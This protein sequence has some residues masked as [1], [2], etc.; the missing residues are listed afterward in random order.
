MATDDEIDDQAATWI[1]RLDRGLTPAERWR[2]EGWLAEDGR[3]HQAMERLAGAWTAADRAKESPELMRLAREM[4]VAVR[5]PRP[6]AY[7]WTA[8]AATA[9]VIAAG[10][11]VGV[12]HRSA[13]AVTASYRVVPPEAR[14]LT[15][16]DGSVVQL[17]SGGSFRA[18]YSPMVRRVVLDKG[19][20]HFAVAKNP[21]RPFVVSLG[22]V[23]V[24]A[25][26]TAIE[27]RREPQ[28]IEILVTEGK[29]AVEDG[30]DPARPPVV[31]LL[32]AGNRAT[33]RLD[34]AGRTAGVMLDAP[35]PAEVDRALAWS[36]T[37]LV[38]DRTPLADA[39]D[40]FNRRNPDRLAIADPAIRG[41]RLGGTYPADNVAGFVRLLSD[42]VDV[43]SECRPDGTIAL[44]PSR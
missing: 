20:A 13:P 4:P 26:G 14:T 40:A 35:V 29:V 12:S 28:S 9:A 38:F 8:A 19:E 11:W 10:I 43:K 31:P 22:A 15:L 16:G 30:L 32:A 25:V 37:W 27:I 2:L 44:S 39:V 17:R 24:R 36:R 5:S 7:F 18:D 6:A 3:N 34:Q 23:S 42:T 33:V 41:I 21:G 1:A